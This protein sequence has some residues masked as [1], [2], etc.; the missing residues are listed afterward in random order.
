MNNENRHSEWVS[1][2]FLYISFYPTCKIK[3]IV[4]HLHRK[5]KDSTMK[6]EKI[7]VPV[8][9][10]LPMIAEIVKLKYITDSLGKSSGWI[11]N[12]LNSEKTTTK[13]K[14]FSQS[15]IELINSSF[16]KIGEELLNT[17]IVTPICE[18]TSEARK[19]VV[20]QIKSLSK[21][22]SM[23]FIYIERL[24]KDRTWYKARMSQPEKYRFKDEEIT[25][26]NM[27]IVEIGNKLLSIE[28]TL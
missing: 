19:N 15:D 3:K 11:Y 17:R 5:K 2:F 8:K 22:V 24:N 16:Y 14:G 25:L 9:Q 26:M 28:L 13:S 27:A 23:P 21:I 1:I 20:E 7:Q 6:T 18:S 4:L 10:G 12:K